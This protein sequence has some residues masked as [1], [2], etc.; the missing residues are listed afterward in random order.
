MVDRSDVDERHTE[1]HCGAAQ[2]Q[3]Q[4]GQFLL[5]VRTEQHDRGRG[6]AIGD[7]G[8]RQ[9]EHDFGG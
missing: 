8:A 7:L 9:A 1:L 2:A 5:D 3:V 4:D 6:V